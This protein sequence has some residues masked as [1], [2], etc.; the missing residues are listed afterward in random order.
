MKTIPLKHLIIYLCFVIFGNQ[1]L[2]FAA[3]IK[4]VTQAISQGKMAEA[5]KRYDEIDKQRL[6]ADETLLLKGMLSSDADSSEIYYKALFSQYPQSPYAGIALLKTGQK[7]YIQGLYHS[8]HMQFKKILVLPNKQLKQEAQYWIGLCFLATN[9]PDSAQVW[10]NKAS[11][12]SPNST[13]GQLADQEQKNI[14]EHEAEV[15]SDKPQTYYAV[16]VGAFSSENNAK[17]R[18]SYFQREGYKGQIKE[19]IVK[20]KKY[21]LVWLGEFNSRTDAMAANEKIKLRYGIKS[22]LVSS[23]K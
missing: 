6:K 22:H 21:Y 8:A 7:R 17:L 1:T 20:G 19:K 18:R 16:Q 4:E 12:I 3:T 14:T 5:K 9:Q 15:N 11:K 13:T 2:A 10:L 23:T